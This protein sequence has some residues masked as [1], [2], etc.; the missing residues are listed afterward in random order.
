V[1]QLTQPSLAERMVAAQARAIYLRGSTARVTEEARHVVHQARNLRQ[2]AALLRSLAL[3][4]RLS[5]P[6]RAPTKLPIPRLA[7]VKS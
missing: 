7:L 1:E 3:A 4:T 2:H 6:A 5:R